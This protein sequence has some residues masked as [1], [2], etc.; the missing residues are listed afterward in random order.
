MGEEKN[1][2]VDYFIEALEMEEK[3]PDDRRMIFLYE[4]NRE[5]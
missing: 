3:E 5:I 1:K 4:K 2:V